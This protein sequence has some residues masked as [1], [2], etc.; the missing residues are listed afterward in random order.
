M[1]CTSGSSY[2]QPTLSRQR[3]G[4][5]GNGY[6]CGT[7]EYIRQYDPRMER[8]YREPYDMGRRR[9]AYGIDELD[10]EE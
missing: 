5:Y 2:R 6:L 7:G 4:G 8:P 3:S 1:T 10:D 9:R